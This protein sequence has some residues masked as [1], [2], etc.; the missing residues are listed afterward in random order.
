MCS[1]NSVKKIVWSPHRIKV[2][3]VYKFHLFHYYYSQYIS[4]LFCYPSELI[5]SNNPLFVWNS[6]KIF[7]NKYLNSNIFENFLKYYN[8]TNTLYSVIF[9]ILGYAYLYKYKFICEMLFMFKSY[10]VKVL[11]LPNLI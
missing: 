4:Y 9:L 3:N 1:Y 5:F 7:R 10:F 2:K 11:L 8:E 6:F